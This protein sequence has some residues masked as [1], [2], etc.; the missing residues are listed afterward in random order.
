L[1]TFVSLSDAAVSD[2]VLLP[3]SKLVAAG[4]APQAFLLLRYGVPAATT[5]QLAPSGESKLTARATFVPA[6]GRNK[7]KLK[8]LWR[9][10]GPVAATDLGDPTVH[11]G[12]SV[13]LFDESADPLRLRLDDPPRAGRPYWSRTRTGFLHKP[14]SERALDNGR[15]GLVGLSLVSGGPGHARIVGKQNTHV[16][17][18]LPF[19]GAVRVRLAPSDTT[20]C[21]DAVFSSPSLNEATR[22]KA[23]SD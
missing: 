9:S 21:F 11:T 18:P 4:F 5:C 7:T 23:V 10:S 20:A 13:C 1:S 2:L 12:V 6:I 16:P 15:S 19:V 17:V 8:W 14:G 22:Y 3:D